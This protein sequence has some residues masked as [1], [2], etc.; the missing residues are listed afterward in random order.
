MYMTSKACH[1]H[2]VNIAFVDV[3]SETRDIMFTCLASL[4]F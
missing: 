4:R 3:S 2:Q 1:V